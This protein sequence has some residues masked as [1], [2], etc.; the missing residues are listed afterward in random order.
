MNQAKL[1]SVTP[2][3]EQHIAYCARVLHAYLD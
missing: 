2:D 3:A 1:I